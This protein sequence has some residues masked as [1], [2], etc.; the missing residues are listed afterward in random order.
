VRSLLRFALYWD[1]SAKC[2]CS[3]PDA[4]GLMQLGDVTTMSN[5]AR[6]CCAVLG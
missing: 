1:C 4:G 3:Q 2:K 5:A 6:R